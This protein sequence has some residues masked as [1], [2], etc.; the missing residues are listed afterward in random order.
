MHLKSE[1]S[2]RAGKKF[3][4]SVVQIHSQ[5]TPHRT[6]HEWQEHLLPPAANVRFLIRGRHQRIGKLA[7]SYS[8]DSITI[9]WRSRGYWLNNRVLKLDPLAFEEFSPS[10]PDAGY[11]ECVGSLLALQTSVM[12]LWT[13]RM[14]ASLAAAA[15]RP[16]TRRRS[17]HPATFGESPEVLL[18]HCSTLSSQTPTS[19]TV[20]MRPN[21][22]NASKSPLWLIWTTKLLWR[23]EKEPSFEL[24]N[25]MASLRGG[26]HWWGCNSGTMLIELVANLVCPRNVSTFP[27]L[28]EWLLF[29]RKSS[30]KS[31]ASVFRFLATIR[32]LLHSISLPALFIQLIPPAWPDSCFIFRFKKEGKS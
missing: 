12:S 27:E 28:S 6:G 24:K 17:M 25:Q 26:T 11:R 10:L 32:T 5:E 13:Q 8:V 21:A 1:A 7:L 2:F 19:F 15:H 20:L 18:E 14:Y 23:R 22:F 16:C 4:A 29:P 31:L 9:R 30:I 3:R